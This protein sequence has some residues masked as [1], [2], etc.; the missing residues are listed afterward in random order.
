VQIGSWTWW[1]QWF[2]FTTETKVGGECEASLTYTTIFFL[3]CGYS[4]TRAFV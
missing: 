4:K 3:R 2:P 1:Q